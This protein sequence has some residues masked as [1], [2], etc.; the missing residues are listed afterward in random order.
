[1]NLVTVKLPVQLGPAPPRPG[2]MANVGRPPRTTWHGRSQARRCASV[3]AGLDQP[4]AGVHGDHR[5][6]RCKEKTKGSLRRSRE[7][8]H[9]DGADT[10]NGRADCTR[11]SSPAHP[12]P[13]HRPFHAT[14]GRYVHDGASG[15][16]MQSVAIGRCMQSV[17]ICRCLQTG[18]KGR[19]MQSVAI[20]RNM[21]TVAIGLVTDWLAGWPGTPSS[22]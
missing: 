9:H 11:S 21:Q 12:S 14:I 1:M 7:G 4:C 8:N 18:F 20:G 3:R 13:S 16:G 6:A 19:C 10:R 2:T 15:R 5:L 17:A 22:T